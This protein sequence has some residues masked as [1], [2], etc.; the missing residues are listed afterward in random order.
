MQQLKFNYYNTSEYELIIIQRATESTANTAGEKALTWATSSS[1]V[2]A[3]IYPLQLQ[4]AARLNQ[5]M[6][7]TIALTLFQC[8]F[9][10][11]ADIKV[12]DRLVRANGDILS[13][14]LPVMDYVTHQEAI[15]SIVEKTE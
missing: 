5:S 11:S 9:E 2:K 6:Q 1:S 8:I 12:R 7:G 14:T 13:V 15:G 3:Q 10:S 4:T